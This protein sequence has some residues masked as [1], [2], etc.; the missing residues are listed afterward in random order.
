MGGGDEVTAPESGN[1]FF[2]QSAI[3]RSATIGQKLKKFALIK[4]KK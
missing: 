4:R 3:F 2:R 1:A